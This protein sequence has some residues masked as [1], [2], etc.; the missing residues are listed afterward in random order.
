MGSPVSY[1][2]KEQSFVIAVLCCFFSCVR[3]FATPWTVVCQDPPSM[4][5]PRQEYWSG[6]PCPP[7]GD[8]PDPGIEL[9]SLMSPAVAD[10]F[11]TIAAA[12]AKLL[13]SSPTLCDPIDSGQPVSPV[14]GIL[15]ARIL[16]SVAISFSN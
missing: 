15:Q 3:L 7:P 8:L 6:L 2:C 13:Q 16:E 4:G 10:G 14:H 11:F 5:F 12:A 9:T 1:G